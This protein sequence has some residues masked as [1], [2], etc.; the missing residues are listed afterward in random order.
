MKKKPNIKQE[1][2]KKQRE[3]EEYIFHYCNHYSTFKIN[4]KKN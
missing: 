2:K 1:V 4:I 3:E